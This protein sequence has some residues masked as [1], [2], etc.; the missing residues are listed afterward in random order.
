[1]FTANFKSTVSC[2]KLG[3]FVHELSLVY[4]IK[5]SVITVGI[6]KHFLQILQNLVEFTYRSFSLTWSVAQW[7]GETIRNIWIRKS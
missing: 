1:M 7:G 4:I 2:S 5:V 3:Q 6:V